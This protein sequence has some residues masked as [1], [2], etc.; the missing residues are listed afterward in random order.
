M[1]EGDDENREPRKALEWSYQIVFR[2]RDS[3]ASV[4]TCLTA[5]SFL[6]CQE[7][8]QRGGKKKRRGDEGILVCLAVEGSWM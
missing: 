6:H 8:E 3:L 5:A 4:R 1:L 7:G 2:Y